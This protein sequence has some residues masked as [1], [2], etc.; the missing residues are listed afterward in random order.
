MIL[1]KKKLR[2]RIWSEKFLP[3]LHPTFHW[4]CKVWDSFQDNPWLSEISYENPDIINS[5]TSWTK[6][7]LS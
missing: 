7:L 4:F 6:L 2:F 5:K 3:G 1:Y